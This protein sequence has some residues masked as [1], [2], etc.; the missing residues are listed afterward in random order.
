MTRLES[1][2]ADIWT[3]EGPAVSFYGFDYPTRMAVIRLDDGSLFVW[4]PIALDAALQT[5]I[6]ALGPVDYLV[7]PNKLH[8]LY[9]PQWKRAWPAARLYAPP[10]LA[11]KRHNIAFD[12][13]A[14]DA[15]PWANQ[16]EPLCFAGSFAMD[17]IVFFHHASRT[18]LFADLIQNF[19]LG[20]FT[21]WRGWVA[22]LDG[23][24][25]P[26]Y[27][28][29]REWRASFLNRRAARR[30]LA[31]IT[32]WHPERVIIAHGMMAREDGEEFIRRAFRWL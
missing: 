9:L 19:P 10:G 2:G 31:R 24:M 7:S 22:R 13:A 12:A 21:G 11:A 25:T 32:A 23:I 26:D 6:N 27:G 17:E 5:E 1:F 8:Y 28:A 20:W 18:A 29:P 15:A 14:D 16:I 4:S 3:A 30:A